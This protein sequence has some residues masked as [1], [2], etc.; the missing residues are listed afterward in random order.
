[1]VLFID[2]T[3]KQTPGHM[4]APQPGTWVGQKGGVCQQGRWLGAQALSRVGRAGWEARRLHFR[5]KWETE[6]CGSTRELTAEQGHMHKSHL[7]VLQVTAA[8]GW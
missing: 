6:G 8:V 5:A 3:L 7:V 2:I 1:M 4:P